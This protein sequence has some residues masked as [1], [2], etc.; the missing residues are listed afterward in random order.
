MSPFLVPRLSAL[1]VSRAAHADVQLHD[2][3]VSTG[4][5]QH[6]AGGEGGGGSR[7]P[8][9]LLLMCRSGIQAAQEIKKGKIWEN[10]HHI[11]FPAV[12]IPSPNLPATISVSGYRDNAPSC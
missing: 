12:L 1:R 10:H 11:G 9:C 5:S 6:S 3:P 7:V 2:I 8:C 4:A